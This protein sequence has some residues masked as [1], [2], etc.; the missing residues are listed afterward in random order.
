M[1]SELAISGLEITAKAYG[2]TQPHAHHQLPSVP[3]AW[4]YLE[5]WLGSLGLP[6]ESKQSSGNRND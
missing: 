5:R 2:E 6:V 4:G 3:L 1:G